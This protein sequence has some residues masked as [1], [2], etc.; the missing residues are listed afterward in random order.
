MSIKISI[1][2]CSYNRKA[3]LKRCLEALFKVD[4]PPEDYELVLIDDGSTDGT[5][6]MVKE[7]AHECQVKC[8]RQEKNAG[9]SKARNL[10]IRNAEGEV[11]LFIDDDTFADAN[12]LKEHW[13]AHQA[14][15]RSVV[16]GWVNHIDN[17]DKE[18]IPKF[19]IADISTSF[20]WTSNVSVRRRFLL[21]AGLFDEDFTEYGWEDLELGHRLKDLGLVKKFIP[22]AIVYHYKTRWKGTDL[23]RLCRQAQSCG[24]SAVIYLRKRPFLRTRMSTGIFFAR[25][26]W[27][28]ILRIGKPFYTKVVKKAGDKPLHGLPLLCARLLVSFEYFD[29]VRA[30]LKNSKS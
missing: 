8:L 13:A 19:K 20:F 15:Q 25:F 28:D 4:F 12:L 7:L 22:K 16:N 29:S 24:R 26:V 23:P 2:I 18:L 17:L 21:E 30:S 14:D 3:L 27:N 10:G 9:L 6:D 11:V 1:Q 5:S